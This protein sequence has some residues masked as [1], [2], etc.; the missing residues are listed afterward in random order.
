MKL[1]IVSI[2]HT[3]FAQAANS[4]VAVFVALQLAV[5][6]SS[7]LN[8]FPLL[9]NRTYESKEKIIVDIAN[10]FVSIPL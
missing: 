2:Y 4:L 6:Y 8:L 3:R 5:S 9:A 10:N 7:G 1:G